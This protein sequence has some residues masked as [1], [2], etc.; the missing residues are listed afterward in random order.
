MPRKR[1]GTVG[2]GVDRGCVATTAAQ[3]GAAEATVG[4]GDAAATIVGGAVEQDVNARD[5]HTTAV[6]D[7][8]ADL[9]ALQGEVEGALLAVGQRDLLLVEVRDQSTIVGAAQVVAGPEPVEAVLTLAIS[10]GAGVANAAARHA[11]VGDT[12]AVM[13]DASEQRA[14][15][16]DGQLD[17]GVDIGGHVDDRA[18]TGAFDACG[19]A[20]GDQAMRGDPEANGADRRAIE[21]EAAVG[22]GDRIGTVALE[23]P[24]H[25][26]RD[27]RTGPHHAATHHA[28]HR[29]HQRDLA[30]VTGRD[31][32]AHRRRGPG[33][34]RDGDAKAP[35][36][37]AV[38]AKAPV[39][40]GDREPRC[41]R[42]AGGLETA[43]GLDGDAGVDHRRAGGGD[44]AAGDDGLGHEHEVARGVA[45]GRGVDRDRAIAVGAHDDAQLVRHR[46]GGRQAQRV[47]TIAVGGRAD[48]VLAQQL[49]T[50]DAAARSV[51]HAAVITGG[52]RQQI[53]REAIAGDAG[54][55]QLDVDDRRQPP[56]LAGAD[57]DGVGDVRAEIEVPGGV[58]DDLAHCREA[59]ARQRA[60]EPHGHAGRRRT[61]A[62]DVARDPPRR[63]ALL[64]QPSRRGAGRER[65]HP[66]LDRARR[67]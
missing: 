16:G 19:A 29:D 56:G 48:R 43:L 27:R 66:I 63:D 42:F 52:A 54:V 35:D 45:G 32:E 1:H 21:H 8:A 36:A 11:G 61:V 28:G 2:T 41:G 44:R 47:A 49:G 58:G 13:L 6:D 24:E 33:A 15:V 7:L 51:D 23:D 50:G 17:G 31:R 14:E 60:G 25:R 67:R 20:G 4:G 64:R 39:A 46:R 57:R 59:G 34:R 37:D 30:G 26:A 9:R 55:A 18:S 3:R 40:I 53:E 12:D 10:G 38:D 5:A 65:D 62:T 22:L